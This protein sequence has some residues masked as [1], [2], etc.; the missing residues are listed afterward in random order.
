MIV[1]VMMSTVGRC[2]A[3][4]MWMPVARASCV[5]FW[6]CGSISCCAISIRSASSSIM[7]TQYGRRSGSASSPSP[8]P[9][10]SAS[11]PF[12]SAPFASNSAVCSA[13]GRR[14]KLLMS[15]TFAR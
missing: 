3:M 7:I 11:A 10:P 2:V 8:S 5:S 6:I 12:A 4:I 9:P 13:F 1:P 15:R 14:L